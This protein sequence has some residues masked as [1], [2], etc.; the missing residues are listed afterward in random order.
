MSQL[1]AKPTK[2]IAPT[3]EESEAINNQDVERLLDFV[4]VGILLA[5]DS[6]RKIVQT[7]PVQSIL[8]RLEKQ[9]A[10]AIHRWSKRNV[11]VGLYGALYSRDWAFIQYQ[12]TLALKLLPDSVVDKLRDEHGQKKSF[13]GSIWSKVEQVSGDVS[14]F[15]SATIDDGEDLA[16]L[17]DVVFSSIEEEKRM[18]FF[19]NY[20]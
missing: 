10:Q 12:A 20:E 2:V 4:H 16:F 18:H 17:L 19:T 14:R 11:F 9:D 15:A 3:I 6:Y 13:F 8:L 7:Y 5:E 1:G